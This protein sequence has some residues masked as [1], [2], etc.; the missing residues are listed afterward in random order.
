MKSEDN[1]IIFKE[2]YI[3]SKKINQKETKVVNIDEAK[4]ES[5]AKGVTDILTGNVPTVE[6]SK[7]PRDS[8]GFGML[9][10][11][12]KGES[13]I[14]EIKRKRSKK[15]ADVESEP[16]KPEVSYDEEKVKEVLDA[17]VEFVK[18]GKYKNAKELDLTEVKKFCEAFLNVT[19]D[20]KEYDHKIKLAMELMAIGKSFYEYSDL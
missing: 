9:K 4:K 13:A 18:A 17:A 8:N 16:E 15:N 1:H 10:R 11:T 3:M 7:L 19:A 2:A 6:G 20:D 14:E 5:A 12:A